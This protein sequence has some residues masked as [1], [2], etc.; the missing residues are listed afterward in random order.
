MNNTF[1]TPL[2]LLFA[3]AFV[4]QASA[5]NLTI[6]GAN[7][8]NVSSVYD[9]VNSQLDRNDYVD[10]DWLD[11]TS[12]AIPSVAAA[13][14][15]RSLLSGPT[16]LTFGGTELIGTI[17]S[18]G[19]ALN[20]SRF[21]F[22]LGETV[23]YT[24][25]ATFT[26]EFSSTGLQPTGDFQLTGLL[27]TSDGVDVFNGFDSALLND[28]SAFNLNVSGQGILGPGNYEFLA[29]HFMEGSKAETGSATFALSLER[30]P[31]PIPDTSSTVVMLFA[32]LSGLMAWRRRSMP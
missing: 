26:G 23:Q 31:E 7:T 27:K 9:S 3:S 16:F 6:D 19:A 18:S 30:I 5:L 1:K 8:Y 10:P 20:V 24:I 11:D 4:Y 17:L 15:K 12:A 13:S 22:T 28:A 14:G 21:A 2:Y 29:S 25:A 32:S